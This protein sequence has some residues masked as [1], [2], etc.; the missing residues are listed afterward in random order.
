MQLQAYHN[1]LFSH[2]GSLANV[3]FHR[4]FKIILIYSRNWKMLSSNLV[5]MTTWT[6]F[7]WIYHIAMQCQVSTRFWQEPIHSAGAEPET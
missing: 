5:S 4:M 6:Q 1:F 2:Q 7:F 3:L